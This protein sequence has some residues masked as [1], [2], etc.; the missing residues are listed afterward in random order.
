MTKIYKHIYTF[1]VLYTAV[2]HTVQPIYSTNLETGGGKT[3]L[4]ALSTQFKGLMLIPTKA[5]RK[6]NIIKNLKT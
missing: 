2:L 4:N 6:L 1:R 5:K 3:R